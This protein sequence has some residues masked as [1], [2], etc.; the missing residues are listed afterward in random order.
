[1]DIKYLSPEFFADSENCIQMDDL[2]YKRS[3][4]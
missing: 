4:L 1:M 3:D 2:T